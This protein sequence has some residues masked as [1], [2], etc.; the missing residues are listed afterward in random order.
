[1]ASFLAKVETTR[2]L[3]DEEE[4]RLWEAVAKAFGTHNGWG[5]E[6]RVEDGIW[7]LTLRAPEDKTL[8][9]EIAISARRIFLNRLRTL[10]VLKQIH[11]R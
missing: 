5:L 2:D 7:T 8:P 11:G 1:M 4:E 3:T 6:K 10:G 9:P